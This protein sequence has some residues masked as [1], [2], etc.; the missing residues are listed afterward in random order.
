MFH[1]P[2]P[3]E[4]G[5]FA[6]HTERQATPVGCQ[7]PVSF[8]E[9]IGVRTGADDELARRLCRRQL[10][11][12]VEPGEASQEELQP[13]QPKYESHMVNVNTELWRKLLRKRDRSES[14]IG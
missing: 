10:L 8:I 12:Q 14:T 5:G 7:R 1:P 11:N 4:E 2:T 13:N 9:N 3:S 6:Q